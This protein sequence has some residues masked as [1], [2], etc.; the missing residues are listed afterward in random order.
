MADPELEVE[1]EVRLSAT[2]VL[3]RVAKDD[4]TQAVFPFPPAKAR[5][6]GHALIGAADLVEQGLG[7]T[8]PLRH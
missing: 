2:H 3:F 1:V 5:E 6:I 4:G 7:A 8:G